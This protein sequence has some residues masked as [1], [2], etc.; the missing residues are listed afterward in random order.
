MFSLIKDNQTIAQIADQLERL[1]FT[2]GCVVGRYEARRGF[3]PKQACELAL[4]SAK[5]CRNER[6]FE[7]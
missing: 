7:L 3:R 2:I 6:E 4:T 1:K 5:G